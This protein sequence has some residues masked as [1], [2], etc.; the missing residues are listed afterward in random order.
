MGLFFR[1]TDSPLVASAEVVT[2]RAGR[3]RSAAYNAQRSLVASAER[4]TL[5][6][7]NTPIQG[8]TEWQRKAWVGYEK[9]GEVHY[10]FNLLANLLS[11]CRFFAAKVGDTNEPPQDVNDATGVKAKL[12]K[13]ATDLMKNLFSNGSRLVRSYSI[14]M[15]VPG[16]CYLVQ[17]PAG[18]DGD[19]SYWDIRSTRELVKRGSQWQLSSLRNASGSGGTI[20]LPPETF[21]ARIW[22]AHPGFAKEPDSSMLGV[23]ESIEE[24]LMLQRLV[25][26]ATRSRLNAGMLFVPDGITG[27]SASQVTA[28]PVIEDPEDPLASL[29][30]SSTQD[31]GDKLLRDLMDSMVTPISVEDAASAVVPMLITGAGDLGAQIRH[32]TMERASDEWLVRQRDHALERVLNGID[33]PKEIVTGL[34]QV[35]YSNAVVIDEGLYKS[36]IEPLSLAFVDSMTKVYLRPQLMGLG[37][38]EK[39]LTDLVV[40]YDP[41]EIVTRPNSAADATQG[42]DRFALSPKAW[43]AEHGFPESYAPDKDDLVTLLMNKFTALPDTVML[44]VLH[45]LIPDVVTEEDATPKVPEPFAAQQDRPAP[46]QPGGPPANTDKVVQFPQGQKSQPAADPQR[47]AIKQVGN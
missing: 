27:V 19:A 30:N 35:K 45:E 20:I 4:I 36:N 39:D 37:W 7:G 18:I 26:V 41:S 23:S 42:L 16:E 31:P 44:K 1:D 34:Q 28:E 43:R 5:G 6:T 14:N 10:G 15:S 32:I 9:V 38:T 25:R 29:A 33:M 46:G 13:D 21:V 24:L 3:A 22:R 17:M 40:W 47:T 11:R 12:A 8:Y 2:G